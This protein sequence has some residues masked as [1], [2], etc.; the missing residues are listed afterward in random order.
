MQINL[1]VPRFFH[2]LK[3]Y[4]IDDEGHFDQVIPQIE[5]TWEKQEMLF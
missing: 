5:N 4:R 2:A 3:H 1:G